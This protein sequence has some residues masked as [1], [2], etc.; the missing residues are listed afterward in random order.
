M[1]NENKEYQKLLKELEK[2]GF[3][4][5]KEEKKEEYQHRI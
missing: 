2:I 4:K 5:F 3:S 1:N